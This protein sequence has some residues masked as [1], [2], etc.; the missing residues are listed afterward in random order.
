MMNPIEKYVF[1]WDKF[2]QQIYVAVASV[3]LGLIYV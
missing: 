3:N 1:Q 2:V